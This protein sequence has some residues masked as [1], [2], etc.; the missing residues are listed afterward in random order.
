MPEFDQPH[1]YKAVYLLAHMG[2]HHDYNFPSGS[3]VVDPWRAFKTKD[4]SVYVLH[5]GDT[6]EK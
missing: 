1:P 5:Y 6:R 2:K 4:D 3:I